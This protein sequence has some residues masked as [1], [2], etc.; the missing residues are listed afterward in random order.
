M[1]VT[2]WPG[3]AGK[4]TADPGACGPAGCEAD[5]T[6]GLASTWAA[7]CRGA[8]LVVA[9]LGAGDYTERARHADAIGAQLVL[10]I[11]LDTGRIPAVYHHGSAAGR[12]W[13]EL[14][15]TAMAPSW[16]LQVRE[17]T[18]AGYPQARGLLARTR[19]PALVLELACVA[20]AAQVELMR[21][22]AP[23]AAAAVARAIRESS[24]GR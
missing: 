18:A 15:A 4:P 3:H 1:I 9:D 8:G 2:I 20:D 14:V 19:A 12:A 21:A 24:D 13:A 5:I 16:P 22:Q 11:H 17:A 23:A 6:P 10:H 7:A